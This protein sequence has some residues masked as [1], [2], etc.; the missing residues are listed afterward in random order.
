MLEKA[1]RNSKNLSSRQQ[2]ARTD[3]KGMQALLRVHHMNETIVTNEQMNALK[4][5][6]DTNMK[7]SESK[8]TLIKIEETKQQYFKIRETETNE[9]I[10]KII[11]ESA[12]VLKQARENYYE[13][14][15]F[16]Y[17]ITSF[18]DSLNVS[19]ETFVHLINDFNERDQEWQKSFAEQENYLKQLKIEIDNDKQ[20]IIKEKNKIESDK[21]LLEIDRIKVNDMRG[22]IEREINRI[23]VRKNG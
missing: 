10:A 16:Y 2:L 22:T 12:E 17:T 6:S 14:T 19:Y 1:N 8:A 18:A 7:V 21:K 13:T 5:L 9:R 11:A 3:D 4:A 15:Q 23:K 20:N